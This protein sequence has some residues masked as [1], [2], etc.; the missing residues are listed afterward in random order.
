[1]KTNNLSGWKITFW[2]RICWPIYL[3][4]RLVIDRI[5]SLS[6]LAFQHIEYRIF[7]HIKIV[8]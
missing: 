8:G 2:V 5:S 3:F 6:F 7:E 4:L 1:M